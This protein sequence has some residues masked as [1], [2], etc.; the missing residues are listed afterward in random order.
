M[1]LVPAPAFAA[2]PPL[3]PTLQQPAPLV[4]VNPCGG[5]RP[6]V[7]RPILATHL[8]PPYPADAQRLNEEGA[9]TLRVEIAPDG[10]V[11]A[12]MVVTS[13][14]SPRLDQAALDF[15]KARYRWEPVDCKVPVATFL[16]ISWELRDDPSIK[17]LDPALIPQ[18][19]QFISVDPADYPKNV[20][21]IPRMMMTIVVLKQDGT[22]GQVAMARSSGDPNIDL[23]AS[24]IVRAHHWQ[25][26]QMDG[27]PRA[28]IL[29]V[30]LLWTPPG[31]KPLDPEDMT[32]LMQLFAPPP[33]PAPR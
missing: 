15:V 33:L 18:L 14:G 16:R 21:Q 32:R 3:T 6:L 29:Y 31:Q 27:K 8:Q 30:A 22:V 19:I 7:L 4:G 24:D 23:K 13:S 28:S 2:D 5:T 11:V 17:S 10:G 26:A 25:P 12:G 20:P 9:T 1:I